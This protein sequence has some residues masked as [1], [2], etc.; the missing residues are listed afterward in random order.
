MNR[1]SRANRRGT[2]LCAVATPI[3]LIAL[4]L[5]AIDAD[6]F[7]ALTLAPGLL[8]FML[9]VGHMAWADGYDARSG[10]TGGPNATARAAQAADLPTVGRPGREPPRQ[11]GVATP[12]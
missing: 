9:G 1:A 5:L 6:D 7:A 2:A 12:P 3:M 8:A 11:P 4:W 10:E